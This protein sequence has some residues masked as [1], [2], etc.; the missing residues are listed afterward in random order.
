MRSWIYA[1]IAA[2]VV[3]TN[4]AAV[5]TTDMSAQTA[6]HLAQTFVG[7]GVTI[8][9]VQYTGAPVAA[10]TFTGGVADGL[11]IASGVI[12]S[13]GNIASAAG[14]NLDDA[15]TTE[16][17]QPGDASLQAL[18]PD[19]QTSLDATVLEFDFVPTSNRITFR[20]VFASDEYNE[21]VGQDYNDIFAFFVDGTNIALIP[22][23]AQPVSIDNVNA[24]MNPSLYR[25]NDVDDTAV[26]YGTQFDGF[27][28]VLTATANVTP[29][30][31]HHIKLAI[32]DVND[33][34]YDSAVFFEA[35][36]FAAPCTVTVTATDANGSETGPDPAVFT[37]TRTGDTTDPLTVNYTIGGTMQ[38]VIDY[39][40]LSGTVTIPAGQ[41]S[42][43]VTVN[44]V[45]DALVEGSE[46]L[47]ITLTA[48]A[49]SPA[50]PSTAT[51]TI[52]DNDTAAPS[53]AFTIA[54][55]VP[56]GSE[57]GTSLRFT[58]T[59]TGS[60][61][62]SASVAYTVGGT[63]TSGVD[64]VA[65][66]GTITIPAGQTSAVIE[67]VPIDDALVEG[68]ESVTIA[69]VGGTC[70][71]GTPAIADG[72][73]ADDDAAGVVAGVPTLGEWALMALA[74]LLAGVGL[75]T[76]RK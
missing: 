16:N 31:T 15:V 24:T 40:A 53:C 67:V 60:T 12:L 4:A 54:P 62:S 22:G 8:S 43:T 30:A 57:S 37:I 11:G 7:P 58:V 23:T 17:G 13:T 64:F 3:A 20:Y 34:L 68:T 14:P 1:V 29:G 38:T 50:T 75:L 49:C 48:G 56:N 71:A 6:T 45:D 41:S 72:T 55:T 46:T 18:L 73:I 2:V 59:R 66:P 61:T 47:S 63:A 69:V 36:S 76:L 10:G 19:G 32:T 42:V 28:V 39:A 27:T 26:P 35:A 52:A 9:N 51:V 74:A 21:F 65:L 70:P 25:N 33:E 44:P 5:T